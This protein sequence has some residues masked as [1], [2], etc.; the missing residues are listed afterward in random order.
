[1]DA[2]LRARFNRS[3]TP[4]LY[5]LMRGDLERRLGCSIPFP[6][7]ETPLF[8]SEQLRERVETTSYEIMAQLV[9]P[10][11]TEKAEET[12]PER[13]TGCLR[14]PPNPATCVSIPSGS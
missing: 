9:R 8:L 14:M 3:W 4:D 10:G 7:A 12:L 2:G 5:R 1:M 13:Y 11:F 6:L